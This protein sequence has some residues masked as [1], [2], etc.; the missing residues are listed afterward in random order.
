[1][2]QVKNE[3]KNYLIGRMPKIGIRPCIDGRRLGVR[4]SL[5]ERTMAHGPPGC[6]PDQRTTCAT[7]TACRSNA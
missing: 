7:P 2:P 1:M 4:E 6:Q 5:E 3:P